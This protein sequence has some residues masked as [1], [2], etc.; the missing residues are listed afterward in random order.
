[1]RAT[2]GRAA[3]ALLLSLSLVGCK[4]GSNMLAWGRKKSDMSEAPKYASSTNPALPSAATAA[5]ATPGGAPAPGAMAAAVTAATPTT[6]PLGGSYGSTAANQYAYPKTPYEPAKL[7]GVPAPSAS[8]PVG[9][10]GVNASGYGSAGFGTTAANNATPSYGT[11]ASYGAPANTTASATPAAAQPQN[12]MYNPSYAAAPPAQTAYAGNAAAAQALAAPQYRTADARSALPS[13]TAAADPAAAQAG[14]M[15]GD[16]YASAAIAPA[17]GYIDSTP[18]AAAA[19]YS[20]PPSVSAS[21][22]GDR[23][24]QPARDPAAY[25]PGNTGYNPGATGYQPGNTGYNPPD[26]YTPP[27]AAPAAEA[28]RQD[29]GYRPGGTSNFTPNGAAAKPTSSSPSDGRAT[30]SG[31]KPASFQSADATSGAQTWPVNATTTPTAGGEMYGSYQGTT[32]TS[33]PAYGAPNPMAGTPGL[34]PAR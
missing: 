26:V 31:V 18:A 23:Y 8:T 20:P 17:A 14:N 5:A 16:R 9:N 12:G 24:A 6:N 3:V 10:T 2:F 28:P 29:S 15:V 1:M 32:S 19:P 27:A 33:E 30:T 4:S 25:T 21:A 7:G 22:V 13:G 11:P 34:F